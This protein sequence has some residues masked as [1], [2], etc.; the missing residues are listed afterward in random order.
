MAK[1]GNQKQKLAVLRSILLEYT[2]KTHPMTMK[3]IIAEL[4]SRGISAERKSI[5]SDIETLI[6][7]GTDIK[8]A[9]GKTVGYYVDNRD[10][11]MSELKLLVDAVSSSK[12]IPEKQSKL[13]IKKLTSLTNIH[14]RPS[15]NRSVFVSDRASAVDNDVL[16]TVDKIHIAIESDRDI[17]FSYFQWTPDKKKELRRDGARYRVSPW[18]LVWDDNNYYLVGF[19]ITYGE[20]RHYRVDKM[21]RAGITDFKRSGEED[22]KKFNISSYSKSVFG[23]FGGE[24]MRITLSCANRLANAMLDRFGSDTVILKDGGRF[25][26]TVNIVPSPVFF[27]WVLS[28]GGDVKIVSPE[29][30]A[31]SL[32]RLIDSFR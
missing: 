30:A 14:D 20:M 7:L 31:E 25:R 1:S 5:Y 2:S 16:D 12:F 10:F 27:G 15:L 9:R 8:T 18:A 21:I 26:I 24:P 29:S 22:F 3:E 32:D 6:M 28:F 11:E 4:N 13:L 19:D 17:A 23:M